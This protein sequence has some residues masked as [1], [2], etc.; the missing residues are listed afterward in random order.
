MKFKITALTAILTAGGLPMWGASSVKGDFDNNGTVDLRDMATLASV[1][2]TNSAKASLHDL[3]SDGKVDENDL[4]A[5]ANLIL[6]ETK[7]PGIDVGIDIGDWNEGGETG[8]NAKSPRKT[9]AGLSVELTLSESAYDYQ[10]HEIYKNLSYSSPKAICGMFI[11]M[12]LPSGAVVSADGIKEAFSSSAAY[13]DHKIYG[14]TVIKETKNGQAA[15]FIVFS[16]SL[17][18]LGSNADVLGS[19][20][21]GWESAD[22]NGEASFEGSSFLTDSRELAASSSKATTRWQY[23]PLESITVKPASAKLEEGAGIQ[24]TC[25]FSPENATVRNVTWESHDKA[26]ATIDQKGYV[27]TLKEGHTMITAKTTDGSDLTSEFSLDVMSGIDEIF[28]DDDSVA[29]VYTLS[30]TLIMKDA[31]LSDLTTL[32]RGCYILLSGSR[33]VKFSR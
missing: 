28:T 25:E 2:G 3:D 21:Y 26:I 32:P 31:S 5:I 1:I 17:K 30:G 24:L 19:F 11:S 18:K 20:T 10:D 12:K 27:K 13:A 33:T 8:G 4:H 15:R 9:D 7:I 29:D 6:T 16:P 22:A 23:I 14:N